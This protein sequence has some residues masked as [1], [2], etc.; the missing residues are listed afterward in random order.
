MDKIRAVSIRQMR[1]IDKLAVSNGIPIELMMENAGRSIA[2]SLKNRFGDISGKN[3]LCVV[4]R[5]NNGGGVIASVRHLLYYGTKVTL[6]FVFPKNHLSNPTKFHLSL[7]PHTK[8][9]TILNTPR[10]RKEILS[11]IQNTDIIIDGIFG[12]GFHGKMSNSIMFIINAINSS[13]SYVISN[14][15][16]SGMNAD[17]GHV[18][19]VSIEADFVVVLHRPKK[20]M[21]KMNLTQSK[22]SIESIGIPSKF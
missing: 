17:T 5:G 4:G 11:K 3:I 21:H 10:N 19:S 2:V 8:I 13:D 15:V 18:E 7:L 16:P 14:D 9:K 6:F 12:T 22:Y 20:W 1:K